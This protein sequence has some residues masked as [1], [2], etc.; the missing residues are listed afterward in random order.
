M[1]ANADPIVF[2][3]FEDGDSLD[4]IFFGGNAAGGGG[5][6]LSDRPQEGSFY[7][8]TG[9]GGNGSASGFYGGAFKNISE[10]DQQ[11]TPLSPWFNVWVLNQSD[12]T[13]DQYTLEITIREDL[14]GNG[15]TNGQEDSF[16]LDT[17]FDASSFND[18]WTL[19]SA[20][21]SSFNNLF[22]G[23]DGTFNGRVD[24]LVLVI[25]GVQGGLGSTVEVDFDYFAFTSG[26]PISV[27]EPT[28]LALLGLGLAGMGIS[29]R[30]KK[31]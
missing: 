10:A 24:E 16:R 5:G 17:V 22:T 23:G 31:A 13:V 11:A 15:W 1:A 29:R 21:I 19:L 2:D 7:L 27:P 9:W 26:G 25:S 8:S 12:A 4:W 6:T 28:S 20:P 30:K 14:D 3:D 18:Q